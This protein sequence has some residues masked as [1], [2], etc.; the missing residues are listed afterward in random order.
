MFRSGLGT[1]LWALRGSSRLPL[2]TRPLITR[3]SARNQVSKLEKYPLQAWD[4]SRIA[5]AICSAPHSGGPYKMGWVLATLYMASTVITNEEMDFKLNENDF[6]GVFPL[7]DALWDY[8]AYQ[9]YHS[10]CTQIDAHHDSKDLDQLFLRAL[11]LLPNEKM[12]YDI[13]NLEQ[14]L[15]FQ[16]TLQCI[17]KRIAYALKNY[18]LERDVR[19]QLNSIQDCLERG[20]QSL[21]A[22]QKA[23]KELD[24]LLRNIQSAS[25]ETHEYI[26]SVL[27]TIPDNP[28]YV[29]LISGCVT[30]GLAYMLGYPPLVT[31]SSGGGGFTAGYLTD[32]IYLKYYHPETWNRYVSE[33]PH[34]QAMSN[35]IMSVTLTVYLLSL[36][37]VFGP[38]KLMRW[39]RLKDIDA[40]K[41]L[42]KKLENAKSFLVVDKTKE[43]VLKRLLSDFPALGG[44]I[45]EAIK[46]ANKYDQSID[47][48]TSIQLRVSGD[49]TIYTTPTA[50]AG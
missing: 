38:E 13:A 40:A 25:Q 17:Q 34:Q 44:L 7:K 12:A 47:K 49:V 3:A 33:H 9:K 8:T 32:A 10:I 1:R 18:K 5:R 20:N 21:I 45:D 39:L 15:F 35:Y 31:A 2:P 23:A 46:A 26:F 22:Q 24:T 16:K 28:F 36:P 48:A 27:K 4:A 41:E 11:K 19:F 37:G 14:L 50:R 43:I 30:A 29:G 6:L 42:I